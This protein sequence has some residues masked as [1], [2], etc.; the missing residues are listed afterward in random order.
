MAGAYATTGVVW[1]F[2]TPI[3]AGVASNP[4]PANGAAGVALNP[5]L[6]WTAGANT[7]SHQIYFGANSN[8]VVNATTNAPEFKGVLAGAS[9]APGVLASSGR[10][11]WRADELAGTY[12]TAGPVWTFATFVSG[13]NSFPLGGGLG[14]GDSFVISF[15]SQVGQTYRVERSESLSPAAWSSV[16]DNMPGTGASIQV[17]D[18][19]V[20]L[21]AQRFYRVVILSP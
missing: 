20:S 17:P 21:Q 6:S 15:P 12:V 14:T 8:A 16:A 11:Y 3:L 2:T 10:F 9:F 18:T 5:T 19:A 13:T 1:S 4:N 7:A